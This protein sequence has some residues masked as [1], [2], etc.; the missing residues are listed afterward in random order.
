MTLTDQIRAQQAEDRAYLA[1]DH[2]RVLAAH[3]RD[4]V[5][6]TDEEASEFQRFVDF[7]A[8]RMAQIKAT[9]HFDPLAPPEPGPSRAGPVIFAGLCLAIASAVVIAAIWRV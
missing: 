5:A 3:H 9:A 8:H 1:A 4:N 2:M 6:L 7:A